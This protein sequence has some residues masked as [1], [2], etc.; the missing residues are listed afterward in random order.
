MYH[1]LVMQCAASLQNLEACFLKA[2]RLAHARGVPVDDWLFERLAPDMKP[3]VFQVQSACDY[4]KA[5]A[6]WL[7][8]TPIPRHADTEQTL[9]ELR[10]RI[11]KTL[12]FVHAVPADA[13]AQAATREVTLSWAPGQVL[14]AQDY[15]LQMTL[16][17]VFFHLSMTYAILRHLG[18]DVGKMDFL[19]TL[20]FVPA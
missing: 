12:D 18:V 17:N 20:R 19:G 16:P 10:Q 2:E 5:A 7:S 4:V 9:D 13:Y 14:H 11:Q 3:L 15:V 1:A 6:G 8:G